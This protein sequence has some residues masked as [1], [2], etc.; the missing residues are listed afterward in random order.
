MNGNDDNGRI[1]RTAI[2]GGTFNAMHQG[3]KEYIKLAFDFADEVKILLTTDKYAKNFKSYEVSP[4]QDRERRLKQYISHINGYKDYSIFPMD[5]E[6]YLINFCITHDIT[7]ALIIP[8][9]YS[10]FEKINRLRQQEGKLSMLLLVKQRTKTTEGLDINSTLIRNL[11]YDNR[12][13]IIEYSHNLK[14]SE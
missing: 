9:N 8:E 10:L 3:H 1:Q 6:R 14:H 5:S 4:Y 11:K 12:M 2:I 7:M 13:S